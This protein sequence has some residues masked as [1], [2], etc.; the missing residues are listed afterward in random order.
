[1]ARQQCHLSKYY[2]F[3]T[4]LKLTCWIHTLS[5]CIRDRK[6]KRQEKKNQNEIKRE[7]LRVMY[8]Q[9]IRELHGNQQTNKRNKRETHKLNNRQT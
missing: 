7:V 8:K 5:S 6:L 1:M 9:Q 2:I 4:P 3:S